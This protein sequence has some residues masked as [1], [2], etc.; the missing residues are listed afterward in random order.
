MDRDQSSDPVSRPTVWVTMPGGYDEYGIYGLYDSIEAAMAAYPDKT[1][2]GPD[3]EGAYCSKGDYVS[4]G[5]VIL[6]EPWEVQTHSDGSVD[7]AG[8]AD[9]RNRPTQAHGE[10]GRHAARSLPHQNDVT[11]E[12]APGSPGYGRQPIEPSDD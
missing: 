11:D 8:S 7:D 12:S 5:T 9:P 1:W 10:T 2:D 4:G 3:K 6:I